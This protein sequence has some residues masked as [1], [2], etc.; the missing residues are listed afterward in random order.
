MVCKGTGRPRAG[1]TRSDGP[2]GAAEAA[3]GSTV[4]SSADYREHREPGPTLR[5]LLGIL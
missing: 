4:R 2:L 1:D 3:P 5:T